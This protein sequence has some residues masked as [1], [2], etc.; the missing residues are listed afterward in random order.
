[1]SVDG[2]ELL[3]SREEIMEILE[4]FD[5][6]DTLR[7]AADLAGCSP[8]T[9]K[10]WVERRDAGELPPPTVA[11]QRD[12]ASGSPVAWGQAGPSATVW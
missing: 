12:G 6:T 7:A 10:Y 9:V 4:A 11:R 2:E 8:N 1:V 5:L 3:K